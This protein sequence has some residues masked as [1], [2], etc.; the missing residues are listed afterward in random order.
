M[1]PPIAV[2]KIYSIIHYHSSMHYTST[3]LCRIVIDT[4]DIIDT[5][6]KISGKN[7]TFCN[8]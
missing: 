8:V 1:T 7:E 5:A 3:L 4:D 6:G 2:A